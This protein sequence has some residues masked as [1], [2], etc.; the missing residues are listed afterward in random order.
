M[1]FCRCSA[2]CPARG[3]SGNVE[4]EVMKELETLE[5]AKTEVE[6]FF[7]NEC[8]VLRLQVKE[9]NVPNTLKH[10]VNEMLECTENEIQN[11]ILGTTQSLHSLKGKAQK[12]SQ[13]KE[14]S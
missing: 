2:F 13:F 1:R 3:G 9:M 6:E 5:E 8:E 14:I 12:I 4:D 7:A 11:Q 10:I